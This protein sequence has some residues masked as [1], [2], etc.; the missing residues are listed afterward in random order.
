MLNEIGPSSPCAETVDA[1]ELSLDHLTQIANRR[2]FE[3]KLNERFVP[4]LEESVSTTVLLLDLDRFK[5]VN[6]SLGHAVGDALLR[7]VA[8]RMGSLLGP[9][10]LLARL[11]GD[12]FGIILG[13]LADARKIAGHL[14]ELLQRTYLIEG[15]PV[16]IG[17]SIGIASA[18]NDARDRAGLMRSAD[19]ALYQAKATGRNCFMYFE[20]EM[21]VRAQDK[22]KM[23]LALRKALALRQIELIYRPQIDVQTK[24]LLGL[25]AV[26]QWRHPIKGLMNSNSFMPLAEEIGVV[27]PIGEWGIKAVCRE[28]SRWPENV[29]I[30]IAV[31][32]RQFETSRFFDIVRNALES[33]GIMGRQLELEVTEGILLRDGRSVLTMLQ[34]L[35]TIGV[36]VAINSFGTG[37]ASLSQ[38]VEFPLDKIT[39]DRTLV[40]ENRTGT[41]ERAIVR[42]IAALGDSLGITTLAEGV[43]TPE[44][45]ARIQM[46]GCT[47]VQGYLVSEAVP[48]PD[49][50]A[51]VGRL[52]Q[53]STSQ[54]LNT[55]A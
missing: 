42:A 1:T 5:A 6:D 46:D 40:E 25:Q 52:L 48:S 3:E 8:K 26:M 43:N 35:R 4:D 14:V 7:L 32:S 24:S 9:E 34:R 49:L 17:V 18:P 39:I 27:V 20:P 11:G 31:S 36:R 2:S 22:R 21:E 33:A 12:E 23:E 30:G 44:H 15:C 47:A 19:L 54:P 28:A 53:I 38:M 45:L 10:D 16:D 50:P 29:T 55:E 51:L 41:K 37:I 13:P